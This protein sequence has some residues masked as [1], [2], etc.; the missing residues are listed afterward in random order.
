LNTDD[1]D[2]TDSRGFLF[3]ALSVLIRAICVIRV[4]KM[5]P[6]LSAIFFEFECIN[7]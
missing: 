5:M 7:N 6:K 4:Q 2:D 1:A 3:F